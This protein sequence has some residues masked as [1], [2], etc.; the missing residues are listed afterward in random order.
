M[1]EI[2]CPKCGKR[3]LKANATGTLKAWCKS[4]K[5]E[6]EIHIEKESQNEPRSND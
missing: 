1:Q 5:E 2:R 4:C 6:V 3:L